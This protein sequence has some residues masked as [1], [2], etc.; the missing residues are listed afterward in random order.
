MQYRGRLSSARGLPT[1][2]TTKNDVKREHLWKLPEVLL[3]DDNSADTNLTSEFL[4]R[5][6]RP[7]H[8]QSAKDGAEAMAFLACE[9]KYSGALKPQLIM[10]DLSMP[11]KDGWGVLADVKSDNTLKTINHRHIY[12][13]PKTE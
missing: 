8:F 7:I 10:L 4:M 2:W 1:S 13:L 5:T 9:G 6:D 11:G 3:V 12:R